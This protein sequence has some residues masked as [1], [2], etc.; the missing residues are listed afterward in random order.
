MDEIAS[1]AGVSRVVLYR[2]F[3]DR[4]GLH[5]ALGE[6]YVDTIIDLLRNALE[7]ETEAAGRLRR[8]TETYVAFIE[9]NEEIYDFLMR[10]ADTELPAAPAAVAGFMSVVAAEI[11]GVLTADISALGLD[12]TPADIWA[13]GVVGMVHLSTDRWLRTRHVSRAQF[14]D[15]L[16][17]LLSYGFLGL[18]ADPELAT[19]IGLQP[20]AG[21]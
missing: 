8:T 21:S 4:S 2:Y 16:V 18:A 13:N 3:G 5:A 6:R 1:E 20:L 17:G 9:E 11:A 14:L 19:S 15:Y 12:P 10:P 7:G